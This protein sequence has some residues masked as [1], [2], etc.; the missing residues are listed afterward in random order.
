[1]EGNNWR[2]LIMI[3]SLLVVLHGHL[4]LDYLIK[5]QLHMSFLSV[6]MYILFRWSLDYEQT[7][8]QFKSRLQCSV[9]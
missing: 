3:N 8:S 1:M 9:L 6:G 7:S 5:Y 4:Y 2:L